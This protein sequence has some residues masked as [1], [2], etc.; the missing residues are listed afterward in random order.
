MGHT[1]RKQATLI[2]RTLAPPCADRLAP[3][4]HGELSQSPSTTARLVNALRAANEAAP[5][6]SRARSPPA[7]SRRTR[8]GR[9]RRT[10]TQRFPNVTKTDS[11][12]PQ[13]RLR[14]RR[15]VHLYRSLPTPP[16][17]RPAARRLNGGVRRAVPA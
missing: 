1:A 9:W 15:D 7:S 17:R 2:M 4:F 3:P 13:W 8:R 16:E 5:L 10:S 6:I 14:R 12:L 11:L